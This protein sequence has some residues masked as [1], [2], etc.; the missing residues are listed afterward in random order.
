[1]IDN[2]SGVAAN[3]PTTSTGRTG[4]SNLGKDDFLRLLVTQ[5][6]H[7]D[8]LNPTDD[9]QFIAQMAQFSSLEQMQNLYNI[10][11]IQEANSLIGRYVKAQ[12]YQTPGEP[13]LVYG[14]VYGVRSESGVNYLLLD[15]GR[16]VKVSDVVSSMDGNGL[17]AELTDMVGKTVAVRVYDNKGQVVNLREVTVKSYQINNGAPYIISDQGESIPLA[18][19]WQVVETTGGQSI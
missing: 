19:V 11:E 10:G 8:P 15:G 1:M 9:T 6:Q 17:T 12:E 5:L 4:T 16:E 18:D 2:V 7:Q 3:K 14:Q 13:D